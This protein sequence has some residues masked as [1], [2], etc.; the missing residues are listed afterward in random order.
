MKHS[1]PVAL[2]A[3]MCLAGAPVL[4]QQAHGQTTAECTRDASTCRQVLPQGQLQGQQLQRPGQPQQQAQ[5]Q[6]PS[7]QTTGPGQAGRQA[8]QVNHGPAPRVGQ[9][10][11][12]GRSF[13]QAANSRFPRAPRGQEYRAVNGHL[14][15][16]DSNSLQILAIMGLL[17][18][19]LQ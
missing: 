14:V 17:E 9:S 16:V 10:A 7:R 3:L 6:A 1:A 5:P 8:P 4:A 19:L 18:A 12:S 13:H 15:L 11:R 2:A